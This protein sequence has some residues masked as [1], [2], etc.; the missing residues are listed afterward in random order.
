MTLGSVELSWKEARPVL[1]KTDAA[2]EPIAFT[3]SAPG[4]EDFQNG[5]E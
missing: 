1:S 5:I 3:T 4:A 2:A